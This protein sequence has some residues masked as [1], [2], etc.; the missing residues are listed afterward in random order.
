MRHPFDLE[1]STLEA[2]ALNAE[3]ELTDEEAT[4]VA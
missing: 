1:I 4:K 2:I 3:N